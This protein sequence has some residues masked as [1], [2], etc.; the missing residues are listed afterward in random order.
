MGLHEDR[1]GFGLTV[2]TSCTR[3][4]RSTPATPA[5]HFGRKRWPGPLLSDLS[6]ELCKDPPGRISIW[7]KEPEA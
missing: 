6:S 7:S 1:A 2:A 5:T 3:A 4:L